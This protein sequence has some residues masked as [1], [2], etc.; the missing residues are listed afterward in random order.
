MNVGDQGVIL[1]DEPEL[2]LPEGTVAT[3]IAF[4]EPD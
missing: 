2:D 4:H 1:D 3:V